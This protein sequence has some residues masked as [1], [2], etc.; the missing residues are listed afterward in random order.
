M[1]KI[2]QN[3]FLYT[4]LTNPDTFINDDN[5]PFEYHPLNRQIDPSI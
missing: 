2:E 3:D 1:S 5:K 4:L